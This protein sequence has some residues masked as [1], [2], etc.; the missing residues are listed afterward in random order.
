MTDIV[1]ELRSRADG[2]DQ[3]YG[4]ADEDLDRD[5]IAE[6]ERLREINEAQ[7]EQ[8]GRAYEDRERLRAILLSIRNQFGDMEGGYLLTMQIDRALANEQHAAD[9]EKLRQDDN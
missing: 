9:G 4:S 1:S 8:L 5:A 7:A 3:F 2:V 6:I